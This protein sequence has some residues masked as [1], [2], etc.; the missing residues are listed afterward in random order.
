ML[1]EGDL[2]DIRTLINRRDQMLQR[3]YER[4]QEYWRVISQIEGSPTFRFA[5]FVGWPFRKVRD[6]L[7]G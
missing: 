4:E 5:R 3:L 7:R 2:T 1:T 6:L